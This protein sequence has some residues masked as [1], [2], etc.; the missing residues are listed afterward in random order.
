MTSFHA[1]KC[2]HL[3]SEHE[4]SASSC[5]VLVSQ[6]PAINLHNSTEHL[7]HQYQTVKR[8]RSTHNFEHVPVKD[9]VVGEALFVEEIAEQLTEVRVVGLVIKT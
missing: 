9:V 3:V 4:A 6:I 7:V 2:C 8:R 5:F 1:T